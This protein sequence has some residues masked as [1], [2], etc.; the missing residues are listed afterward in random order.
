MRD[1]RSARAHRA[2]IARRTARQ[3]PTPRRVRGGPRGLRRGDGASWLHR[4]VPARA[5]WDV[6]TRCLRGRSPRRHRRARARRGAGGCE[7]HQP[8]DFGSPANS[9]ARVP[10]LCVPGSP[11]VCL[12]RP[13]SWLGRFLP[14]ISTVAATGARGHPPSRPSCGPYLGRRAPS[15]FRSCRVPRAT[16]PPAPR[17]QAGRLRSP[18]RADRRD[19]LPRGRG[20]HHP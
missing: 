20:G 10:W 7:A 4:P 19:P 2:L 12:C 16:R 6:P 17:Q 5:R 8:P 1:C 18:P 13:A 15:D 14:P 9:P 3:K 11:R